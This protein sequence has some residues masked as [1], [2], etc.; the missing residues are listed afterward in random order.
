MFPLS[1]E[2]ESVVVSNNTKLTQQHNQQILATMFPQ[3][4]QKNIFIMFLYL[5][6]GTLRIEIDDTRKF[7]SFDI[8]N[9]LHK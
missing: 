3:G 9:N 7:D 5:A 4:K 6:I 1:A 2:T 8:Q